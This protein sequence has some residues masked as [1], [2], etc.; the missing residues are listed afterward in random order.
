MGDAGLD[1][2]R[3]LHRDDRRY[4]TFCRATWRS[5]RAWASR[6]PQCSGGITRTLTT[7][8]GEYPIVALFADADIV[9]GLRSGRANMTYV[10]LD[11]KTGSL[12]STTSSATFR[13]SGSAAKGR[14]AWGLIAEFESTKPGTLRVWPVEDYGREAARVEVPGPGSPLAWPGRRGPASRASDGALPPRV[15]ALALSADIFGS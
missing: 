4:G 2:G 14:M 12:R 9:A 1:R 15:Q 11:A 5:A 13:F 7:F 10:V 3:R 6:P 8:E